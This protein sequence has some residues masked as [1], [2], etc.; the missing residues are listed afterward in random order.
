MTRKAVLLTTVLVLLAALAA[1]GDDDGGSV[2]GGSTTLAGGSTTSVAVT[3][4]TA[5]ESTTTTLASTTTA[6]GGVAGHA[7]GGLVTDSL[8]EGSGAA[9]AVL[10]GNEEECFTS[11]L[12][13]AI[14]QDRFVELD[15]LASGA[16]DMSEVF[17]QM[18]D[19][20]LD[21]MVAA[22]GDCI[23]VEALLLAE[24]A[25]EELSPEMAAC[26][27]GE[28]SQE[29]TLNALVRAMISGEDPATNP[30]FIAIM[31]PV[32]TEDCVGPME[33]MLIEQFVAGG[34]SESSAAC[35]A[36]EFLRGGLFESLL[37]TMLSGTD[38]PTDPELQ[39]QMMAAFTSCLTPDELGNLGG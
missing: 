2:F 38:F 19:P 9:S 34:I 33:D 6:G 14:G 13:Q 12:A 35:L 5:A 21:A 8:T 15:A 3:T 37:N 17:S 11:G 26:V 30:E 16:A 29:D 32:M 22:I 39:S 10:T 4:S 31:M 18:T 20:E 27:A 36:D 25:G 28:V 7:L 23:D 1:C 24:M